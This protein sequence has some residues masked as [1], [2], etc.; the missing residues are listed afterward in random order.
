M[1]EMFQSKLKG[2]PEGTSW[3]VG[4]KDGFGS[5][6]PKGKYKLNYNGNDEIG[7]ESLWSVQPDLKNKFL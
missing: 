6:G 7:V 2:K 1:K 4:S 3:E 5:R